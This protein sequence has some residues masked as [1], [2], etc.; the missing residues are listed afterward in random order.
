MYVANGQS[1]TV[2]VISGTTVVAN[3]TLGGPPGPIAYDPADNE[4]YVINGNMVSVLS[5]TSVVANVTLASDGFGCSLTF[6]PANNEIYVGGNYVSIISG[7]SLV[8]SIAAEGYSCDL[9]FNPF[10]NEMYAAN[11]G[12]NTVAILGSGSSSSDFMIFG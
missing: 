10:N 2:S 6:D 7:T 3:V 1:N 12:G 5:G 8:G 9:V 11:T 4:M